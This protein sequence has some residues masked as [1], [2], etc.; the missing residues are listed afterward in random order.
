[1][2]EAG[3]EVVLHTSETE[4]WPYDGSQDELVLKAS[5]RF[6][7]THTWRHIDADDARVTT[8]ELPLVEALGYLR[9]RGVRLERL[10][11]LEPL[12]E[13]LHRAPVLATRGEPPEPRELLRELGEGL[14]CI[15]TIEVTTAREI[16]E[17]E[18]S[19]YVT[20]PSLG[21]ALGAWRDARQALAVRLGG[22]PPEPREVSEVRWCEADEARA[23]LDEAATEDP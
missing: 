9:E 13:A 8:R 10:L 18:I 2:H 14:Y 20:A 7:L 6:V 21:R 1:M 11:E 4:G 23:F 15:E 3:D 19:L 17:D 22:E 12:Q 5:G 16:G